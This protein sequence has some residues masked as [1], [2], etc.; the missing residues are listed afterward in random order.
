MISILLAT[1]GTFGRA[2][3]DSAI[4]MVGKQEGVHFIS[5]SSQSLNTVLMDLRHRLHAM[6]ADGGVLVLTDIYGGTPA[7]AAL[8]ASKS[9]PG[10]R[11][12]SGLSLP[13]LLSAL[14]HRPS[15][16]LDALAGKVVGDARKGVLNASELL[17]NKDTV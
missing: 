6:A 7:N 5:V 12:I 4:S 13:M 11:V 2:I 10:C 1:H 8:M 16:D 3:L 17:Q 9:V 15:M 14:L